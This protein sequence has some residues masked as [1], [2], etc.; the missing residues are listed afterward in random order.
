MRPALRRTLLGSWLVSNSCVLAFI[1]TPR[2][3]KFV[4]ATLCQSASRSPTDS[5]SSSSS[6]STGGGGKGAIDLDLIMEEAEKAERAG[7]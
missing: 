1:T 2:C 7:A 6:S 3:S 4:P 5:S